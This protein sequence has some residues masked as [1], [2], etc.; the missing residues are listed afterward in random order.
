MELRLVACRYKPEFDKG[1]RSL[2]YGWIADEVAKVCPDL[3]AYN[4]GHTPAVSGDGQSR[5]R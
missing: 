2:Q 4:P 5:G 1:E 3:A